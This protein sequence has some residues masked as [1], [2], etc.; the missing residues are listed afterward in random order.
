[1]SLLGLVGLPE[2]MAGQMM[3]GAG[4]VQVDSRV[5]M[6]F[7]VPYMLYCMWYCAPRSLLC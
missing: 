6:Q 5:L 1:M 4:P 7:Y 3:Q 2:V